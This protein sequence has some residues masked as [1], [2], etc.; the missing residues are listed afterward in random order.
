MKISLALHL[1]EFLALISGA[2]VCVVVHVTLKG[3]LIRC[4]GDTFGYPVRG[5]PLLC[6]LSDLHVHINGK[7]RPRAVPSTATLS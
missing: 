2:F 3:Y 1:Y 4:Y 6:Y 7:G 5:P